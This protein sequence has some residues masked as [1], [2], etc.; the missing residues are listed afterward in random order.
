M[1]VKYIF[2]KKF[3]FEFILELFVFNTK[4][5]KSLSILL[6]KYVLITF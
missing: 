6:S 3:T 1:K 2:F 4:S 5:V